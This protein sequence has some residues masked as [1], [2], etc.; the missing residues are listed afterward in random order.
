MRAGAP[1]DG[2]QRRR[3]HAGARTQ[4]FGQVRAS[5]VA[6]AQRLVREE[7]RFLERVGEGVVADVVQQRGQLDQQGVGLA[8]LGGVLR[9]QRRDG[10]PRQM[11]SAERMLEPA[12]GGAGIDEESVPELPD[13]AQPLEGGRVDHPQGGGLEPDVLPE[14]VADDLLPGLV[15]FGRRTA[16]RTW[17]TALTPGGDCTG[18]WRRWMLRSGGPRRNPRAG[19]R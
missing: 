5:Q 13:V 2:A 18:P 19:R 9:A 17:L 6:L 10:A 7:P 16:L 14:Q 4:Q 1:D 8:D 12:V 11:V 3:L 15:G